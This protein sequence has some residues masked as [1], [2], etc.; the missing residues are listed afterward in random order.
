MKM[1]GSFI[2][3]KE[4]N[5]KIVTRTVTVTSEAHNVKQDNYI[6]ASGH[7]MLLKI[8]KQLAVMCQ[9]S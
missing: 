2:K 1:F 5:L 6:P 9:A 3:L 7:L 4:K 8:V